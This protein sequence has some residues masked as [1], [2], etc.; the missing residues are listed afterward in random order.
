MYRVFPLFAALLI[1]ALAFPIAPTPTPAHAQDGTDR[2]PGD[3]ALS[4]EYDGLTR[5]YLLHIPPGYDGSQPYPLV[6]GLHGGT[7]TAEQFQRSSGINA[8]ADDLGFIAVFPDGTGRLQTWNAG[9]CCGLSRRDNVDDV[10]FIAALIAELS[11]E[12][13]LDPARFYATGMSNGAMM[14]YRLGAELPDVLA[15]I[16]PVAGSIGGQYEAGAPEVVIPA[17]DEPVSVIA[18]NGM[19]DEAV[20]YEGGLSGGVFGGTRV[21]I[22][23]ADSI[24]FWVEHNNCDPDPHTETTA[25]GNIIRD[26]YSCPAGVEV[27]L[28]TIVDGTHSWPGGTRGWIGGPEPNRDIS[29][30]VEILEFFLAHPKTG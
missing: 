23:V 5:T 1:L 26:T 20:R 17:P 2:Q 24:A 6:I 4:M 9:H 15:G 10:G 16:G 13:N 27:V 14:S 12:L 22:S 30:T 7:G 21:D 8:A 25:G 29:A 28:I 3:Y 19:L 18:I 11:A